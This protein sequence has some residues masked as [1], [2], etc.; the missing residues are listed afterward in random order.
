MTWSM[1]EQLIKKDKNTI[2]RILGIKL[3]N[4]SLIKIPNL[5]FTKLK[6]KP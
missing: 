4:N 5:T 3:I 6:F 2:E 1:A